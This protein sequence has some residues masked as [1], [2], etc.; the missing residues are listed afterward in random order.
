MSQRNILIEKYKSIYFFLP[1]SG[2]T[3]VKLNLANVLGMDKTEEFPKG[4]HNPNIFPFPFVIQKELNTNYQDF[5]KFTIVRNP[6]NR[7][8]S[9]YKDKIHPVD[10]NNKRMV[11]GVAR[12]LLNCSDKFYGGMSFAAFVDVV[13]SI[14]DATA[15]NHFRSQLYQVIDSN[16]KLMVNYIGKLETLKESLSEISQKTGI[17]FNQ[18]PHFHKSSA[19]PYWEYYNSVLIERVKERYK[20]DLEFF[21]YEFN[22]TSKSSSL[23]MIKEEQINKLYGSTF[24]Q[25]ILNEKNAQLKIEDNKEKIKNLRMKDSSSKSRNFVQQFTDFFK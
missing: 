18:V 16:G 10:V 1:K 12:P 7:L 14:S 19:K 11:N 3:S 2:S 24:M 4:I 20:E 9:C 23:G 8:V 13:C 5:F 21:K 15:N 25:D 22:S 6:W 17:P